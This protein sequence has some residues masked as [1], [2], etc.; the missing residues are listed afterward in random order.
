MDAVFFDIENDGDLDLYVVSGGNKYS[1]GSD[2]LEDRIYLND[3]LGRFSRLQIALPKSNGSCV[4]IT[5]YNKDGD[6]DFFVGTRSV[7]GAY[8]LSENSFLFSISNKK[9][10]AEP[11][12]LGM[13]TDAL[14]YDYD[15]DSY[16]DL[17]VIGDWMPV[18]VFKNISGQLTDKTVELGLA[19]TSGLWNAISIGDINKDGKK[20]LI[21]GNMGLNSKWQAGPEQ[22]ITLYID[23]FDGNDQ[24]DPVIFYWFGNE[25]IPFASKDDLA[26]Q[27]PMIK[28][29]FT[30]YE[31]FSKVRSI[32]ALVGASTTGIK[33][34]LQLA[35]VALLNDKNNFK[36]VAL[37]R[38]AQW[39]P[40]QSS[41]LANV[42]DDIQDELIV[43]GN[44][45][46]AL[47]LLGSMD[48]SNGAIFD[49]DHKGAIYFKKWLPIPT[50][51]DF[52]H[53]KSLDKDRMILMPNS[54]KPMIIGRNSLAEK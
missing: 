48:A 6:L 42:D 53:I 36:V 50:P 14:W 30:S 44:F 34:I 23:D 15:G 22:P 49:I 4:R 18:T 37:P 45:F 24:M 3:G 38:E 47:S 8:G 32:N 52:R 2:L 12:N 51:S 1:Q 43:A 11:L 46:G 41:I 31:G 20:D 9:A 25:F 40:V 35:S 39:S 21:V 28:K 29:R 10:K 54:G 17:F 26:S 16:E 33:N 7:P 13:V 27:L 19:G 5:D